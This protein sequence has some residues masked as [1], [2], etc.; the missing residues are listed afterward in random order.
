[1]HH[2]IPVKVTA[3]V[4]EGVAP[5]VGAL[6]AH[7]RVITLDSCEGGPD[8]PAHVFFSF[9]GD[10]REAALFAAEIGAALAP[11]ERDADYSLSAEWRPGADGPVLR[12]DCPTA[13]ISR[14][15]RALSEACGRAGGSSCRVLRS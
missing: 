14:L 13:H 11:H 1:M 15:A 5:L 8:T 12:I 4:D 9:R 7:P 6:N 3:W 10:G 2:E